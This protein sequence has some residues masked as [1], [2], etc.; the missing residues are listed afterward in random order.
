MC[1]RNNV[2][3]S[4]H[5]QSIQLHLSFAPFF[6]AAQEKREQESRSMELFE[7]EDQSA[8]KVLAI[9]WGVARERENGCAGGPGWGIQVEF[10]EVDSLSSRGGYVDN[11]WRGYCLPRIDLR[12]TCFRGVIGQAHTHSPLLTT[13]LPLLGTRT[14]F[15]YYF[16]F[17]L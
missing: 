7:F 12:S 13:L 16:S 8:K 5:T 3:T 15:T 1:I 10:K 11:D 14:T 2:Y 6:S 4:S 17:R 9:Q